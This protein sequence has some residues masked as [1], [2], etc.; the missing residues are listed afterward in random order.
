MDKLARLVDFSIARAEEARNTKHRQTVALG[1][2]GYAPPEQYQGSID[3]RSDLYALAATLHFLLTNRD[4]RD[5]P[6]FNY[7]RVRTLNP[8]LSLETERVLDR[9]LLL[10]ITKRYQSAAV[11]KHDIDEILMNR[12]GGLAYSSGGDCS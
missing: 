8:Q 7:P 3:A 5:E 4:P 9:A 12:F 2:L 11:M 10:D 1:T 6:P